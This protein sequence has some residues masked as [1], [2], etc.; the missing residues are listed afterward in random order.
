MYHDMIDTTIEPTA[1]TRVIDNVTFYSNAGVFRG[2]QPDVLT[3][4]D[5]Q[6]KVNAQ[7][8]NVQASELAQL[9]TSYRW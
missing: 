3:V 2:L 4:R 6:A 9:V 7:N 8:G 5:Y 1:T